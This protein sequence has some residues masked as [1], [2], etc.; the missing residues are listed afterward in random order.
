MRKILLSLMCVLCMIGTVK[1]QA[2]LGEKKEL[3][4]SKIKYKIQTHNKSTDKTE[5]VSYF[6]DK[7][8]C[9]KMYWFRDS[10]CVGYTLSSTNDYVLSYIK[11]INETYIK[12]G[13]NKWVDEEGEV[14]VDLIINKAKGMFTINIK[15]I[16][17]EE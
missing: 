6:D 3:I 7:E 17:N 4:L 10:I 1:S 12:S 11:R 8:D 13:T 15:Y 5:A 9:F 14:M 2:F 16:E